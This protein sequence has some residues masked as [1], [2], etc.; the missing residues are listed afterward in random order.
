M[1]LRLSG[2]VAVVTGSSS[3]IGKAIVEALAANDTLV[4]I[5][6]AGNDAG[7]ESVSALSAAMKTNKKLRTINL[8]DNNITCAGAADLSEVLA[9][10]PA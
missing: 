4:D 5:S 6:L 8:A 9:A 2:K 3:G 10:R 7:D 1:S